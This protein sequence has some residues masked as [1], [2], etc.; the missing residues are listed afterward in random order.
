MDVLVVGAGIGGLCA[1][2]G[3]TRLGHRVRI[4]DQSEPDAKAGSGLIL[5][6]NG[7]RALDRIAPDIGRRIRQEAIADPEPF[8]YVAHT[9]RVKA[10]TPADTIVTKWHAPLV[11]VRRRLLLQLLLDALPTDALT[12]GQRLIDVRENESDV[13][14]RFANSSTDRTELLVGADGVWSMTRRHL[15]PRTRPRYLGI[16]SVRGVTAVGNHPYRGGFFSQG[17]GLQIFSSPLRSGD[18]YWA[19]TLNAAEHEWPQLHCEYARDRLARLI[20]DWHE[21]VPRLVR[22]TAAD[23]MV[24]TDVHDVEPLRRW[25]T[26]R[27]TLI[28]DAAHAMAPFLGQGAN[29]AIEDAAALARQ[30]GAASSP[31]SS[32]AE[33]LRAYQTL[34]QPR[35]VRMCRMSRRIGMLGQWEN[36]VAI[37]MRDTAMRLA[38]RFGGD[39]PESW[40]YG[41]DC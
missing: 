3:L 38:L 12:T 31:S 25:S 18:L 30:V 4:V 40:L 2:L 41:Y 13:V 33:A 19:A 29:A 9:G 21:P 26:A 20:R 37:S 6:P 7:I 39:G 34:R 36:R 8:C 1:A 27:V 11:P 15:S 17:P 28:G 14:A 22:E 35:T 24:L 23:Q 16:T 5:S 10:R 32:P